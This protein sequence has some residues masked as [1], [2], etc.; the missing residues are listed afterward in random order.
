MKARALKA[1]QT[2][3]RE[4]VAEQ[5]ANDPVERYLA[6]LRSALSSGDAHVATGD[7]TGFPP[8]SATQRAL[9]WSTDTHDGTPMPK[10]TCIG[11]LE[12]GELYLDPIAAFGVVRDVG[13][14]AGQQIPLSDLTMRKRLND[15]KKLAS[16]D[17]ATA[18][19]TVLVRK[20][21]NGVRKEVL[22][23]GHGVIVDGML[24]A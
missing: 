7:G 22:H 10:G 2:L 5:Q 8:D 4:Q 14:R 3:A 13:K 1:L 21:L 20:T 9:G 12:N 16:T 6:Y 23:M 17:L 19:K 15:A 11:W 24:G 18:R